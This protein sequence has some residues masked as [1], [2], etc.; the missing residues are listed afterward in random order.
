MEQPTKGDR[1]VRREGGVEEGR[2]GGREIKGWKE[3][4]GGKGREGKGGVT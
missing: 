3:E 2:K 4:N 1:K